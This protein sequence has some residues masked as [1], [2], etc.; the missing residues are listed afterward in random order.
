MLDFYVTFLHRSVSGKSFP[1]SAEFFSAT[2][3][4]AAHRFS[5]ASCLLFC[6]LFRLLL[7]FFFCLLIF[8]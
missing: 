4:E 5:G 8:L 2:K 1:Q 7:G 3:K 6:F